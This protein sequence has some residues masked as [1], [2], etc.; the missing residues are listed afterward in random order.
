M[1]LIVS[2]LPTIFVWSI[3]AGFI[4]CGPEFWAG[5]FLIAML[6]ILQRIH[7][8]CKIKHPVFYISSGVFMGIIILSILN[9]R[10]IAW[11]WG[12]AF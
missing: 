9:I 2:L 11:F 12:W 10:Y 1:I 5:L 7:A 3:I 4:I 8:I 6:I